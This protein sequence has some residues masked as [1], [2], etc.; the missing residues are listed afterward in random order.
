MSCIESEPSAQSSLTAQQCRPSDL[1]VTGSVFLLP[2]V[3]NTLNSA[4]CLRIDENRGRQLEATNGSDNVTSLV[5]DQERAPAEI[6]S[7]NQPA[8]SSWCKRCRR[9]SDIQS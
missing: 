5:Q 2:V 8:P 6:S 4:F 1:L 7:T 9:F 3:V